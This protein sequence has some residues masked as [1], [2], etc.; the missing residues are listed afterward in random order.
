MCMSCL[1][2]PASSLLCRAPPSHKSFRTTVPPLLQ[3]SSQL[4]SMRSNSTRS[5]RSWLPPC[6]KPDM[7]LPRCRQ[8]KLLPITSPPLPYANPYLY[9]ARLPSHH[10]FMRFHLPIAALLCPAKPLLYT[11]LWVSGWC[12]FENWGNFRLN[13]SFFYCNLGFRN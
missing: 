7:F 10:S 13:I 8:V 3:T 11:Q 5:D 4:H 9:S 2:P 1:V 12:N 6:N